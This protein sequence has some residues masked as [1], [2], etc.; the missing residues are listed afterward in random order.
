MVTGWPSSPKPAPVTS[1]AATNAKPAKATAGSRR[2][3]LTTPGNTA[4]RTAEAAASPANPSAAMVSSSAD[5]RRKPA[6]W[7]AVDTIA[8]AITTAK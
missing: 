8:V 5:I 2:S 6:S 1:A 4:S 7:S 3:S